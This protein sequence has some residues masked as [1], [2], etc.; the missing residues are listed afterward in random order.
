[1]KIIILGAGG[2][3]SLVG[4][5]LS[6]QNDVVLIGREAHV[7]EINKNGLTISGAVNENFKVKAATEID[8]INESD[9]IILTTKA[10]DNENTLNNIKKLI[11]KNNI[12]LCLQNGLG[13]EEQIKKIVDCEV[14]RGIITAGTTFLEPGRI[15]CAGMG[16]IY[17]EKSKSSEE[18][19]K[20][21][22]ESGLRT[23]I[24]KDI[25]KCIFIINSFCS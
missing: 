23:E 15:I 14:I 7:N 1:M 8:K 5:F 3:G 18:I 22:K 10:V 25:V 2:V 17:L 13:N 24:N 20:M 11:H 21:L 9:L 19:V 12:I 4:G 16:N 6:K